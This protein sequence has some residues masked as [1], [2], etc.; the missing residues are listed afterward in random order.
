MGGAEATCSRQESVSGLVA[1]IQNL[2]P[3]DNGRAYDFKGASLPW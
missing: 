1:V 3:T 2:G